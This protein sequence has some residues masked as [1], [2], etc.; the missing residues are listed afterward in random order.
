M[1]FLPPIHIISIGEDILHGTRRII[2]TRIRLT[3]FWSAT[4]RRFKNFAYDSNHVT[5]LELASSRMTPWLESKSE[6]N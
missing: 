6:R 4:D 3:I 2:N 1:G 5:G